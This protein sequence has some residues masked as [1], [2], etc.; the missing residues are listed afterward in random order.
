MKIKILYRADYRYES[1][2]SFSPHIFRLFPKQDQSIAIGKIAFETNPGA[3]VQHRK[4]IFDNNIA[5]CF[6]PQPGTDLVARLEIDLEVREKNAF[7]FL[8]D[9]HAL[10]FPFQYTPDELRVLAP[11]LTQNHKVLLHFWQPG[12]KPTVDAL[13]ELNSALHKNIAYERREEGAARTPNETLLA[14]SGACRDFAVLLAETLRSHG[15]AA[16]L[17]SG[18]LCEFGETEKRAEGALHAWTEAY[19]P[20]AGW[21]GLD[22]TNGVFCNHNHITTALGLGPEDVSPVSGSYFGAHRVPSK[23]ETSLEMLKIAE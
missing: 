2:V 11:Y 17:A 5:F 12:I 1:E 19:L 21:I 9:S 7:H 4:D 10:E 18:Y 20:G 14:G 22:P 13:V 16:R 3:D 23:M 15:V 8:L 6:Y